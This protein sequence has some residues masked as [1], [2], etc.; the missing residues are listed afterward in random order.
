MEKSLPQ[1]GSWE[2]TTLSEVEQKAKESKQDPDVILLNASGKKFE[3]VLAALKF[4]KEKYPTSI[5]VC[6]TGAAV[7]PDEVREL[8]K[9]RP[10]GR[11]A[12]DVWNLSYQTHTNLQNLQELLSYL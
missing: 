3:D 1:F 12:N 5:R 4:L 2:T 11:L 10:E 9:N 8:L 6:A 7:Y